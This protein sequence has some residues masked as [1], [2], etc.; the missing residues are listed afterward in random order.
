MAELVWPTGG[1]CVIP[2]GGVH[3]RL[4]QRAWWHVSTV[5]CFDRRKLVDC[6]W[7]KLNPD[8][9]HGARLTLKALH[10]DKDKSL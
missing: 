3:V 8:D 5:T 10:K 1:H 6:V 4:H 9:D 2:E 7:R